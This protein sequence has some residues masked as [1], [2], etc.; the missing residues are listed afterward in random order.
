MPSS[1]PMMSKIRSFRCSCFHSTSFFNCFSP[2][3]LVSCINCLLSSAAQHA[4]FVSVFHFK[5]FHDFD[6]KSTFKTAVLC[7]FLASQLLIQTVSDQVDSL[8]RFSHQTSSG[9]SWFC[10]CFHNTS[11]SIFLFYIVYPWVFETPRFVLRYNSWLFF[12]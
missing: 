9:S 12:M 6:T 10:A 7:W 3:T 5:R 1:D 4:V 2:I 8:V 11:Y